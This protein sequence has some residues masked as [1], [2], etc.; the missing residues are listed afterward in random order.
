MR[1]T[2]H[3]FSLLELMVSL[4]IIAI[5][6]A[7]LLPVLVQARREATRTLCMNNVR[8]I[9]IGWHSYLNDQGMFPGAE[10]DP[11]WRYAG[12]RFLGGSSGRPVADEARPLTE[13]LHE[14][15]RTTAGTGATSLYHCPEDAGLAT[16]ETEEASSLSVLQGRSCFEAYGNSYR[17][18]EFLLDISLTDAGK[19]P[20]PLR[21]AEVSQA[22]SRVL[23][24]GDPV[25][26]YAT[27]DIAA[28]QRLD[29]S[30]HNTHS[31]GNIATLDGSVRFIS[32]EDGTLGSLVVTPR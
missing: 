27:Q 28:S 31:G 25:W 21:D 26:Y 29:A 15:E 23:L 16:F 2:R 32:F 13:Y 18:N 20:R 3:A 24:F 9:G 19:A 12:V 8:Q 1:T 11:Y 17:A 5:L 14:A 22:P 4:A 30:W 7:V 10:V 6:L